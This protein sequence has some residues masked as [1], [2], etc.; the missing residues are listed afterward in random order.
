MRDATGSLS[1]ECERPIPVR[2]APAADEA[3]SCESDR[4][5]AR[6]ARTERERRGAPAGGTRG[7]RS[8]RQPGAGGHHGSA[9]RMHGRDDLL[10]IDPLQLDAGRAEV[11]VSQL[12][13]D[14]VQRHALT[15]ELE[16]VRMAQLVRREPAPDPGADGEPAELRA[17]GRA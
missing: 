9:A 2:D 12:A 4:Q 3:R 10:G 14:D 17:D 1:A 8:E 13:L 5:G 15:L 7:I 6:F 11:G 16:R